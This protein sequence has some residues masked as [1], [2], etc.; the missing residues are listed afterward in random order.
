MKKTF[1]IKT[2]FVAL[3]ALAGL[4]SCLKDDSH[5]VDFAGATPLVELPSAA[6]VGG[7]G[8]LFQ[9][10]ALDISATPVSVSL[11]VNLAAPKTLGSDLAVK[12][13]VDPAALT[14]YN[15]ANG[16]S[17]QLLPASYY[18]STLS[19]TI[20]A[21]T[22]LSAFVINVN[23]ALIDPANTNYVLPLTITDGGGQQISNYKTVLYN[24]QVKNKYDGDY[25]T[26]GTRVH[27][28]LGP[29]P[30]SYNVTMST[31]G[32]T[33]II[34]GALADLKSDLKIVVN[35]DNS[36]SLSSAA[37]PSVALTPG[38]VNKYDPATKTFTLTYFYNT[39]APRT[40]TQTLVKL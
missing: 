17:Y 35:A 33:S 9:A 19:A 26:T 11:A 8:G 34:G 14:A 21:G 2:A 7:S 40:I 36:V 22:N 6:N 10:L 12:L 5:Y 30:F 38:G 4:S 24:V 29:F 1:Y 13:S 32:A 27:P 20:K 15:T 18:T 28:T 16:T 31:A 37:Q 39:A 23:S 3:F 25:K